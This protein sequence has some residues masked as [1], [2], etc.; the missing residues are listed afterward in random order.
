M[1]A[2]DG[3]FGFDFNGVYDVVEINKLIEYKI[4]GGREVKILFTSNADTT[5]VTEI[6][7]QKMKT[8]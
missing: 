8:H 2:K 7:S 6:L 5:I 4:E 1:E 3:S